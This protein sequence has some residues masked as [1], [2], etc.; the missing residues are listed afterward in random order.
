M[1]SLN[2]SKVLQTTGLSSVRP[3]SAAIA[4]MLMAGSIP[5]TMASVSSRLSSLLVRFF[6][7]GSSSLFRKVVFRPARAGMGFLAC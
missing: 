2:S 7:F 4:V 6:M 3:G 5:S 1:A